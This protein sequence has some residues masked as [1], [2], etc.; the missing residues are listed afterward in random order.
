[1][2][3][4]ADPNSDKMQ[5]EFRQKLGNYQAAPTDN[6]WDKIELSLDKE[7][8]LVYKNRFRV[9]SRLA[10]ACLLLLLAFSAVLIPKELRHLQEES[11][12]MAT[13][14]KP[15]ANGNSNAPAPQQTE[16]M[17]PETA[18]AS[19]P[20]TSENALLPSEKTA[21]A[22][23]GT[24]SAETA[25]QLALNTG[26]AQNANAENE[27]TSKNA[28]AEKTVA[29]NATKVRPQASQPGNAASGAPQNAMLSAAKTAPAGIPASETVAKVTEISTPE[30]TIAAISEPINA[31]RSAAPETANAHQ[32]SAAASKTAPS[33]TT[34]TAQHA[35][36]AAAF[37]NPMTTAEAPG[38][39]KASTFTSQNHSVSLKKAK[40]KP[41]PFL[42]L[43]NPELPKAEQGKSI[44]P[45]SNL[46]ATIPVP[47]NLTETETKEKKTSQS[48]KW[49][50]AL[51]Y[52]GSRFEAGMRLANQVVAQPNA[53]LISQQQQAEN[54]AQYEE[55]IREF[56]Q[57]TRPG[58]SQGGALQ[59]AYKLTKNWL[60]QSGFRYFRNQAQTASH[61]AFS[62]REV[63]NTGIG[64]G[65]PTQQHAPQTVLETV[66]ENSFDPD[67]TQILNTPENK[68]SYVFQQ[69]GVPV[70]LRYQ[71]NGKTLYYF[72]AA[73]FTMNLLTTAAIE[74]KHEQTVYT[75]SRT[76]DE[77][78]TM[79]SAPQEQAFRNWLPAV[80]LQTGVGYQLSQHWQLEM[81]LEG[82]QYLKPLI[83]A[84][85]TAGAKQKNPRSVGA[86]LKLG[87]SF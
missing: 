57:E 3:K 53:S 45:D 22:Y 61:Y 87:Y 39:S 81:A 31:T 48:G 17:V 30:V 60:L 5:A 2:K 10:A 56:N 74:T 38:V 79:S 78:A 21:R 20:K 34:L 40:F 54:I 71:T 25:K 70:N 52:S 72:G 58:Y 19:S 51:A 50:L 23:S 42:K 67:K 80:G 14:Q 44:L 66:L 12:E 29:F 1:M 33:P 27:F 43:N 55:A 69:I 41:L 13:T 24:E 63:T 18:I 76:K 11:A 85:R 77:A 47:E 73:G 32:E 9:Y 6:L 49:L 36:V 65:L 35:S 64:S 16:N 86:S 46:L 68:T 59:V 7:E 62:T 8:A 26:T 37:Q 15:A 84:E 28:A 82:E 75:N 4:S 83:Q